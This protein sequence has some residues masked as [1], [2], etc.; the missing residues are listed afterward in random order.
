MLTKS[1]GGTL[2]IASG[3]AT[4]AVRGGRNAA[5]EAILSCAFTVWGD[6]VLKPQIRIFVQ[7]MP[8]GDIT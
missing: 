5:R 4:S 8:G 6:C 7:S 3:T 2:M 1:G